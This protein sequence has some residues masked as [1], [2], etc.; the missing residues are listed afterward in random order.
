MSKGCLSCRK[1][2]SSYQIDPNP[3][4]CTVYTLFTY[5]SKRIMESGEWKPYADLIILGFS[6][7]EKGSLIL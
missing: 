7:A 3:L 2:R 6:T 1:W 5:K 4:K